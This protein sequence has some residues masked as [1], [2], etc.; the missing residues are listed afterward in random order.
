MVNVRIHVANA[1]FIHPFRIGPI[2]YAAMS[3]ARSSLAVPSSRVASSSPTDLRLAAID[4]GSNSIHMVIAQVDASGGVTTLWRLKEMVGL[5]RISFPSRRLTADAM[6]R[7]VVTLRRFQQVAQQ[8]QVEKIVAVATS[9]VREAENGGDF[10]ERV[11]NELGLRIRV[12][13]GREE[14][15]LIYLGVKHAT[16]LHGGPHFMLDIGGGSVE[17]IVANESKPLFLESAKLGS[18]RVTAKFIKSDPVDAGDL[19]RLLAHYREHLDPICAGV[20][21]LHPVKAFGTSGTLENLAAMTG[22]LTKGGNGTPDGISGVI[23]RE[24]LAILLSKLL[25]SRAK[26]RAKM[27]GLDDKRQDQITSGAVLVNE[28]FHR[29]DLKKIH[30]CRGALREGI[31]ID[32]LSRHLP[33]MQVRREVSD[34][35]RRSVLDLARRCDWHQSHSE[36]V[37]RLVTQL[38]DSMR[39]VHALSRRDR[40]LIEYGALL[41]DIGWHIAAEDHHKHSMYLILHGSL[42]EFEPEEVRIIANIAR[43]HRKSKPKISHKLFA[44]LTPHGQKVV[45]VGAALLR[46]A[47]ALDRTHTG[48]VSGIKLRVGKR[49]VQLNVQARGDT[50]MELWAARKKMDLFNDVFDRTISFEH[51]KR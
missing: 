39:S 46:V 49:R 37:A 50:E 41:H 18:A 38:F 31:L 13:S 36:Q 3:S 14:A 45:K 2:Q 1:I 27:V 22:G 5:G 21:A 48:V 10:L 40:D 34:P 25:E 7:A 19:R 9:A 33:E 6:D 4:V 44:S 47:D 15:R 29:L 51:P 32:Y 11:R 17:F 23:E 20:K 16:D 42:K 28:L 24:K 35:R 43:Y 8:R 12:V 26:D 30:V